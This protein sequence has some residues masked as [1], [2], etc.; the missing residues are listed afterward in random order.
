MDDPMLSL[1]A[2]VNAQPAPVEQRSDSTLLHDD[3]VGAL[4]DNAADNLRV[5]DGDKVLI[6]RQSGTWVELT[7]TSQAS[8]AAIRFH[9]GGVM[10][11]GDFGQRTCDEI[12]HRLL[13]GME[14]GEIPAITSDQLDQHPVLPVKQG[15]LVCLQS[16]Q[17]VVGASAGAL[18]ARHDPR[19]GVNLRENNPFNPTPALKHYGGGSVARGERLLRRVAL[20]LLG[21]RK[22][23]DTVVIPRSNGGKSV[24]ANWIRKATGH[25]AAGIDNAAAAFSGQR[26]KFSFVTHLL[27]TKRMVILDEADKIEEAPNPA[28]LNQLTAFELDVEL[29]GQDT[30][31]LPRTGNAWFF[32]AD[33]PN[34]DTGQGSDTRLGWAYKV[35]CPAMSSSMAMAILSPDGIDWLT[36]F[37]IDACVDLT[38]AGAPYGDSSDDWGT[39]LTEERG[40]AV[41]M[42]D[43][44]SI[45][46]RHP[47]SDAVEALFIAGADD[48]FISNKEVAAALKTAGVDKAVNSRHWG[49]IWREAGWETPPRN[50]TRKVGQAVERGWFGLKSRDV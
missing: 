33:Y 6:R 21:P 49:K 45:A 20:S 9:I 18:L 22:S 29:K 28:K 30:I 12:R 50:G 3:I 37:L 13:V 44:L 15:G 25:R 26:T 19:A 46:N 47:A 4:L 36:Q 23:I 10:D 11:T 16:G 48:D 43:M 41:T 32:G 34:L 5:L 31:L 24:L 8:I 40:N 39:A 14:T 1:A 38:A 35:D 17:R 27:A 7:H 42:R 2:A